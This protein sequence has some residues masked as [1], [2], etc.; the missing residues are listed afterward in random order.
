[1]K[2]ITRAVNKF[3]LGVAMETYLSRL[4]MSRTPTP[5]LLFPVIGVYRHWLCKSSG[6]ERLER[7]MSYAN[8]T[9]VYRI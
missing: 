7:E 9:W 2:R 3:S 1:M 5:S 8:G 4:I 6:A